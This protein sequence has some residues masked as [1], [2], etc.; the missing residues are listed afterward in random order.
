MGEEL[1]KYIRDNFTIDTEQLDRFGIAPK[2]YMYS[3]D[4]GDMLAMACHFA[5]WQKQRMMKESVDAVFTAFILRPFRLNEKYP[6]PQSLQI[7]DKVKLIII[8]ED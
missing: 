1:D 4:K 6:N 8:K 5:E 7:G 3:M 2:D